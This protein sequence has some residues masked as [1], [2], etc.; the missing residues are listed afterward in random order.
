MNIH[1]TNKELFDDLQSRTFLKVEIGSSLYGLNNSSS[2][3]D[4]L[5]IY[6][7]SQEELLSLNWTHHQFQFKEN[8]IDH[9][10]TGLRNF[11]RNILTGDSTINFEVLYSDE[12]KDSSLNWLLKYKFDNYNII[13]SYLGLA[14][15]DIKYLRYNTSGF[16]HFSAQDYKKATHFLRGVEFAKRL[17]N[18]EFHLDSSHLILI[19]SGNEDNL[20]NILLEK[21]IEMNSLR[22]KLN[23]L[24]NNN[25]IIKYSNELISLNQDILKNSLI[26]LSSFNIAELAIQTIEKG[27][28][29][30]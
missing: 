26:V 10:F 3:L 5:Y 2:D 24:L 4:Y 30:D 8:N 13:K 27:V 17:L 29:Y 19:K 16:N 21:E 28:I 20:K 25:Q 6:Q 14:K 9:N 18:K 1:F 11:I 12:I 7:E 23:E 22:L 15:R